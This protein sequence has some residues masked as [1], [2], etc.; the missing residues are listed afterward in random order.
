MCHQRCVRRSAYG[1]RIDHHSPR[2]YGV[3]APLRPPAPLLRA[4]ETRLEE[5]GG[6]AMRDVFR[7]A[8]R[9]SYKAG[10]AK[11]LHKLEKAPRT[12]ASASVSER[13]NYC[14]RQSS[15]YVLCGAYCRV[16]VLSSQA[17]LQE[18]DDPSAAAALLIVWLEKL[19][20][21][22]VPLRL[23]PECQRL[24]DLKTS[25]VGN[26]VLALVDA[27]P[28][29]GRGIV[30]AVVRLYQRVDP[31]GA[32][33]AT[34]RD[35]LTPLLLRRRLH[36]ESGGSPVADRLF[37]ELM[38]QS[39]RTQPEPWAFPLELFDADGASW[40]SSGGTSP[41]VVNVPV[42]PVG[43]FASGSS[44]SF[45]GTLFKSCCAKPTVQSQYPPATRHRG[46]S[47]ASP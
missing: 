9:A 45:F 39:A 14:T 17:I 1:G 25:A 35:V 6:F 42:A 15:T 31:L 7:D 26:D 12:I 38:V 22:P 19:Q 34:I 4:V 5:L 30:R 24:A 37:V 27:F 28:E 44:G 36:A 43:R 40:L 20:E 33:T 47:A 32:D 41:M 46:L 29:P 23:L 21:S 13:A 11:M 8:A 10:A 16:L 2:S 18:V 3:V